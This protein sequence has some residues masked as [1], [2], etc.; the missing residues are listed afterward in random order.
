MIVKQDKRKK[1]EENYPHIYV[2]NTNEEKTRRI[3]VP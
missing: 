1:K 3:F 2:Y